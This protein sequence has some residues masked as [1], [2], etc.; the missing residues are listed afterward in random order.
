MK[1]RRRSRSRSRKLIFHDDCLQSTD[2]L[3]LPFLILSLFFLPEDL[4][5]IVAVNFL[6]LFSPAPSS[7]LQTWTPSV[8]QIWIYKTYVQSIRRCFNFLVLLALSYKT[9]AM[10]FQALSSSV[11]H[12]TLCNSLKWIKY[13]W[14][15]SGSSVL[16]LLWT[17]LW[18]K[19]STALVS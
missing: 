16:L 4:Q 13:L 9:S 7:K 18:D 15:T 1:M 17:A 2:V 8:L 12:R 14:E 3:T 11:W 6:K 10:H 5:N 19:S